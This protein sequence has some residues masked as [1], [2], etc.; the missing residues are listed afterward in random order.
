[1]YSGRMSQNFNLLIERVNYVRKQSLNKKSKYI[2]FTEILPFIL[3]MQK[4][5]FH[6]SIFS[7]LH[8][9]KFRI[10]LENKSQ[11][12]KHFHKIVISSLSNYARN[13]LSE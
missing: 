2:V 3:H 12:L 5:T 11:L 6:I 10:F 4:S 1:M 13:S 7:S 8:D 9:N